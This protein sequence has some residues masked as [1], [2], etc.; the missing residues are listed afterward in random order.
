MLNAQCAHSFSVM[1]LTDNRPQSYF[2]GMR[3]ELKW[4]GKS[5]A[6]HTLYVASSRR[7]TIISHGHCLLEHPSRLPHWLRRMWVLLSAIRLVIALTSY[8]RG[9]CHN[10][11]KGATLIQYPAALSRPVNTHTKHLY[12]LHCCVCSTHVRHTNKKK[13]SFGTINLN[14]CCPIHT[15]KEK[16]QN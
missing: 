3:I 7:I 15:K 14:G 1:H 6:A 2:H 12:G 8:F 4:R 11:T 10:T 5:H 16:R 13:G 9:H